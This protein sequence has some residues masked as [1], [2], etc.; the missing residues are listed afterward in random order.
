MQKTC[1]PLLRGSRGDKGTQAPPI[2]PPGAALSALVTTVRG[3]R[4]AL[5][6][7]MQAGGVED[8]AEE[9]TWVGRGL[10]RRNRQS[11]CPPPTPWL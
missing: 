10:R 1:R 8:G 2:S 7:E 11:P 3:R 9:L 4:Q 6:T 5:S